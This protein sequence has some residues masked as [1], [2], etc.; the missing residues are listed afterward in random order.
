MAGR[1]VLFGAT[2][3]TGEL[4][5]RTMIQRGLRPVLAGRSADRLQVLAQE[6]GGLDAVVADAERPESVR[7][8]V[9]RGDVL[10]TT[11]GPFTEWGGPAVE[12]AVDVG[13]HYID[14]SGEP[15]FLRDV[16]ERH[17]PRA[18]AAGCALLPAFGYD[19][20]PGNLAGA[21]SLREAGEAAASVEIGYYAPGIDGTTPLTAGT[22][23]T[24]ARIMI[25]PAYAWRSG[26]LVTVPSASKWRT[27]ALPSGRAEAISVGG[28]EHFALPRF[29]PGLLDVEVYIGWM[30]KLSRPT[31]ALMLAGSLAAGVP[32][33]RAGMR[34]FVALLAD[35]SGD[36]P[37]IDLRARTR[38]VIVA[39]ACDRAGTVLSDVRL[40]GVDPYSLS[41]RLL[42][43]GAECACA[44]RLRGTGALGPVDA[45]GLD[46]LEDGVAALGLARA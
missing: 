45:V 16:F 26:R 28:T 18:Q 3:Y 41:A 1:I 46:A 31:Q 14:C 12:A 17:G 15:Q 2:G 24:L 27:F 37:D 34:S 23:A 10:V 19:W 20:V 5:A 8:L 35:G 21:L 11:V 44:G 38:S 7:A 25:D 36:G 43:W 9:E 6:L 13:A 30:G 40:E 39:E 4:T 42:A 33:F 29:W 22:R 32:G